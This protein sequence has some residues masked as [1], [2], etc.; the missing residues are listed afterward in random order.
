MI[1]NP[2]S[3]LHVSLDKDTNP[4]LS[5][6]WLVPEEFQELEAAL[7]QWIEQQHSLRR[8]NISCQD[9]PDYTTREQ[10]IHSLPFDSEGT[11]E[12]AILFAPEGE[13]T[14]ASEGY[15][16]LTP[17][18]ALLS[19]PEGYSSCPPSCRLD[20]V[21]E[22]DK[23]VDNNN[24]NASGLPHRNHRAPTQ[25]NYQYN[26]PASQWMSD[27]HASVSEFVLDSTLYG[28][29]SMDSWGEILLQLAVDR[30]SVG[31]L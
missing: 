1:T 4:T 20:S 26:V 22:G 27:Q 17:E 21:P 7:R 13:L 24:G 16:T 19:V 29:F 3:R 6:K 8:D 15:L 11:P 5:D 31:Q 14:S 28:T 9:W 2:N 25:Y 12:G 30:K 10:T 18:G 23:N